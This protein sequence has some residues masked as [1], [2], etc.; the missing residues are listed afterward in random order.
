M[1]SILV[2]F[3][4]SLMFGSMAPAGEPINIGDR[5]E[6]FVD[7]HLIDRVSAELSL[8]VQRPEPKEVVLV[9]GQPWEGNT[10]AYYSIFRDGDLFRMYYRGSH[11]INMKSAHEEVTCYAE[12]KDGIHWTKPDLGLF[13]WNGSKQNNIVWRGI[14][15]HCFVAFRDENPAT[16]QDAK[17][18]GISRGRPGGSKGLYVFQSPDGIHWSLIRNQPVITEGYFDSQNLAFWDPITGQYV[19]YHRTFVNGVRAIMTC[20]SDDFVHWSQPKLLK[21]PGSPDQHL[22]TNAIRPCPGAPHIRIGFPTRYLPA[23]Q[24][25]EPV[26]MASRDGVTFHRFDEAIIPQSAPEDRDGNRSNYMTNG[27][28]ELPGH[29][30]EWSV[31]ATEA[32]Y[33][34]PDSRLRRFVY[35]KDGFVALKGTGEA[36][37]KP[38]VYSGKR[39]LLNYRC[40]EGGSVGVNLCDEAGATLLSA[41]ESESNRLTGDSINHVVEWQQP[42]ELKEFEGRPVRLRLMLKDAEVYAFQFM[43]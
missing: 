6:L 38:L 39:L 19:D 40:E 18:K 43:N 27:L 30:D 34:G 20:V 33:S 41:A 15:T 3:S 2:A 22:Y 23:T 32:Y 25:V 16:H 8:T 31:Y 5:R 7:D 1:K 21:Y 14:G 42:D 10:C 26:F 35:R 37:T 11:A 9:T 12:S 17:Y 28:V 24:Q 13:E 4:V 29:P 36:L